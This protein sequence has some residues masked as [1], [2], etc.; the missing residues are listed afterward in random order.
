LAIVPDANLG[1]LNSGKLAVNPQST[2][3]INGLFKNFSSATLTGGTYSIAGTMTFQNANIVTNGSNLTLTGAGQILDSFT[4]NN[5]L[6]DFAVNKSDGIVS[7]R[8][9]Q[10]LQ[11]SAASFSNAGKI[12]VDPTS[13]LT[14][15]GSYTQTAG[16]TTIDGT[17]N[18]PTGVNL[19]A[20]SLFGKGKIVAAVASN[21]TGAITAGDSSTK[22]G[23]LSVANYTQ[24]ATGVLNILI[25]GTTVGTNYG[26]L[27]SSNGPSL[28]GTL[29][30][31]RINGFVPAIGNTFTI[32]TGNAITGRF[33]T[34]NGLSI[35]SSEHLQINY[36][37]TTVTLTVVSGP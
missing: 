15:G 17:L 9:G 36:N 30:I 3:N 28:S 18:A 16:T 2:L 13:S 20:G 12:T 14:V 24:G 22:P 21:G 29:N 19:Q 11:S 32:I 25:G 8:L 37:A 23:T 10:A 35:N 7:L 5:A 1:F 6:A 33:T 27:A 31:Q 26:Q 34:V 4:S